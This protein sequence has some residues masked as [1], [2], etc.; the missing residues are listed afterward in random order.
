VARG[1][2]KVDMLGLPQDEIAIDIPARELERLNLTLDQAAARIGALSQDSSAGTV[3]EGE[4]EREIRATQQRRDPRD[5]RNLPLVTEGGARVELA[6]VAEHPAPGRA[7][8]AC[9]SSSAA[10]RRWNC[11]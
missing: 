8:A 11:S 1:V 4:I 5:F 3:G 9:I 6:Q 10:S 7:T 2:D